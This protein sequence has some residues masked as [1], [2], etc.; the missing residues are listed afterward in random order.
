MTYNQV[1]QSLQNLNVAL[2]RLVEPLQPL[3]QSMERVSQALAPVLEAIAPYIEHFARYH[4]FIDSVRA[5]GWLPYYTVPIDYAEEFGDDVSLL[6]SRLT[7]YYEDNWEN[8][9]QDIEARL[10]QYNITDDTKDTFREALSA[11]NAGHYRCVCRVLFPEIDKEF[12]IHFFNN[13]ACS[14]S[15]KRMLEELTN[16]GPLES[17]LPREAYGWMLFGLLVHHLY[18]PV[19]DSNR[20]KYENDYVPNRHA[21]THGLASY[22]T[23]KHSMNMIVMADYVFQVLTSTAKLTSPQQQFS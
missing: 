21:S 1:F 7:A 11:H 3:I 5:T 13:S 4:K 8:I 16:R 17:F 10:D 2:Q 18:E 23:F 12:R 19:D 6:E 9:R 15:S 22:S 14:I 20:A